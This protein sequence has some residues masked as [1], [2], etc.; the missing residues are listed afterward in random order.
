M[1]PNLKT[2][3]QETVNIHRQKQQAVKIAGYLMTVLQ[4]PE[5]NHLVMFFGDGDEHS[6]RDAIAVWVGR[7]IHECDAYETEER[8]EQ[9][10][11]RA[12]LQVVRRM[13]ES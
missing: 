5:G 10:A 9:L 12:K 4:I 8:L 2:L 1:N 3:F 6:N 13:D 7:T 11:R